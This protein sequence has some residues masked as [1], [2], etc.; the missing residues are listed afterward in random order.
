MQVREQVKIAENQPKRKNW[1]SNHAIICFGTVFVWNIF[2]GIG[3][4]T[5]I[6]QIDLLANTFG[7]YRRDVPDT[8]IAIYLGNREKSGIFYRQY[9]AE[10]GW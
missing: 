6:N 8:S 5:H 3:Y 4:Q 7:Y 9:I 1:P 10:C 2:A